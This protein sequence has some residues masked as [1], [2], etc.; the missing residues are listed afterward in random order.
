MPSL[1]DELLF[2]RDTHG[3]RH[4]LSALTLAKVLCPAIAEFS[5]EFFK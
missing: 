5:N 4:G 3:G 2:I 1:R